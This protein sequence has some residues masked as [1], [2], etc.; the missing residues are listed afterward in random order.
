[1]NRIRRKLKEKKGATLAEMIV[2]FALTA[3]FLSAVTVVLGVFL[4]YHLRIQTQAR[5]QSVGNVVMNTVVS[6]LS[7]A[8]ELQLEGEQVWFTD[9]KGRLV[10]MIVNEEG[11]LQFVTDAEGQEE[12]WQYGENVYNGFYIEGLTVTVL[13]EGEALKVCFSLQSKKR[14][15]YVFEMSRS[16][17]SLEIS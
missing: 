12:I 9:E 15:E 11:H 16:F 14:P 3:L 8:K 4:Q 6:R 17:E 5:A 2:T 10:E 7:R 13:A 1:M